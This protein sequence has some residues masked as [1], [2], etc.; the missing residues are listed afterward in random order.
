MW[1]QHVEKGGI[2][3][4]RPTVPHLHALLLTECKLVWP[5]PSRWLLGE[6]ES[7]LFPGKPLVDEPDPLCKAATA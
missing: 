5:C 7:D 3:G 1:S 2:K 4:A 6:C